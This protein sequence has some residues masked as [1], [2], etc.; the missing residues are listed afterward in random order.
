MKQVKYLS[1]LFEEF[2][3]LKSRKQKGLFLESQK[4]NGLFK[5]LLQGAFDPNIQWHCTKKFP[6]Y[7]PDDKPLGMNPSSLLGEMS[8]C[9]IFAVGHPKSNG[10]SEKRMM[11][12]LIQVLESMHPAE[13]M[14]FEQMMK[15]K[16]KVKGLTEKLVL[17]VFPDLYREV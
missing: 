16:L 5:A 17:E 15:K 9:T 12:L 1:E 14:L 4:D 13:S 6:S 10:V 7:V 2:N 8:R 3:N 11:E